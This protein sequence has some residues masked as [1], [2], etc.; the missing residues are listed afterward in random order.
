M[1][2]TKGVISGSGTADPSEKHRFAP[3]LVG[4]V[5]LNLLFIFCVFGRPL[6]FFLSL[7]ANAFSFVGVGF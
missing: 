7:L 1:T 4:F 5:L 6:F 3:V 2:S